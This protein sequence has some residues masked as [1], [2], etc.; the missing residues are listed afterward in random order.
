[1]AVASPGPHVNHLHCT[2]LQT[3]NHAI[4]SS[5]NF[6]RPDAV[7]DAQS[8]LSK[9]LEGKNH[10]PHHNR[11]MALFPGPPTLASAR[12]ELLDFV[13]QGKIHNDHPAGCHSIHTYQ[14]PPPPSPHFYRPDALPVNSVKALNARKECKKRRKNK[15]ERII[16]CAATAD[17]LFVRVLLNISCITKLDGCIV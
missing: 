15:N 11:F 2:L 1:M 17:L 7:P 9:R 13:V 4:T 14:C 3:D 5:L 6:Y 10:R 16:N 8:T 12:R